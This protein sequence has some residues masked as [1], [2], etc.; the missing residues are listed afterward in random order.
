MHED[1]IMEEFWTFQDSE[2]ARFLRMQALHKVLNM[3][4]YG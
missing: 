4:E 1:A 3:H 2:H